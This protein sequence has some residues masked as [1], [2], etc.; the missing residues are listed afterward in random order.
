VSNI[1][2][3]V[4]EFGSFLS[5]YEKK[6]KSEEEHQYRLGVF[7]ENMK[8]VKFLQDTEQATGVYGAT[9]F[10]DLTGIYT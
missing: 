10:A 1:D 2:K 8:K 5:K 3:D 6:Y 7:K 4:E 9:I